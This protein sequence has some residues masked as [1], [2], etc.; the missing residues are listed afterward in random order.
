MAA[1]LVAVALAVVEDS[2]A[3]RG[4][5]RGGGGGGYGGASNGY[6][7]PR[8][9][10]PARISPCLIVQ[11]QSL[12]QLDETVVKSRPPT[13]GA[14]PSVSLCAPGILLCFSN[15]SPDLLHGVY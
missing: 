2:A 1:V 6:S 14:C 3:A 4:G 9:A 15:A 7:A 12:Y 13:Q 11:D 10:S 5:G 8:H